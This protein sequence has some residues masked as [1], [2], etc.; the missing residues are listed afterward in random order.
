[1]FPRSLRT[2][3]KRFAQDTDGLVTVEFAMMMPILFFA[4][5][6]SFVFFDAYRQS[7]TNLKTAYTIGDLISRETAAINNAYIDSMY[8][9]TQDLARSNSPMSLRIS[10]I[11]WD[12]GDDRYYLDWSSARGGITQLTDNTLSAF[13]ERLPTMPDQERVILVETWNTW[14]PPF[15]VGMEVTSIDNFVFT[16]PRFAP[17]LAWRS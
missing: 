5:C 14:T 7:A 10:V 4:Y 16:R 8:S 13:N 2:R 15:N 11:R 12:A 17:Q 9:L 3:I 1:M 6:A